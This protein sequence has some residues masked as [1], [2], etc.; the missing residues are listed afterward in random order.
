MNGYDYLLSKHDNAYFVNSS[1]FDIV[2]YKK[3]I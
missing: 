2:S 1:E 3:R